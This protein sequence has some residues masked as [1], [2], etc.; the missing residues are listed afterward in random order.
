MLKQE[1]LH[2]LISIVGRERCKTAREDLLTYGCDAF[3]YEYIPD[4]VVSPKS[5]REPAGIK[6]V[7]SAGN[8]SIAP[9]GAGS[10]LGAE[11]LAKCAGIAC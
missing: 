11:A 2:E 5:S 7:A 1:V 10:G 6:K 9:R 3:I 4:A 8:I